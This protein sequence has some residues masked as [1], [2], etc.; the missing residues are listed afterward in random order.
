MLNFDMSMEN[1]LEDIF[2]SNNLIKNDDIVSQFC[3]NILTTT[4][5][6]FFCFHDF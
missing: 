6:D 5:D 3:N 1:V 4:T 2:Y